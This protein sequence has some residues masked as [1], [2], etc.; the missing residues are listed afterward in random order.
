MPRRFESLEP[1]V[2]LSSTYVITDL[3]TLPDTDS[4]HAADGQSVIDGRIETEFSV[5]Q[6]Q[7]LLE[8]DEAS[9]VAG[10]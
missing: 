4:S 9:Q 10:S 6:I 1:R 8:A 7:R 2:V 5:D 3:G